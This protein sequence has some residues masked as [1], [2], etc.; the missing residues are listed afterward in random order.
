MYHYL[1]KKKENKFIRTKMRLKEDLSDSSD[2]V[3]FAR[4]A[5]LLDLSDLP[6]LSDLSDLSIS[7]FQKK[8]VGRTDGTTDQRTDRPLYRDAWTHLKSK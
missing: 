6:D 7:E 2:F 3:T 4:F 5:G 8:N 1:K